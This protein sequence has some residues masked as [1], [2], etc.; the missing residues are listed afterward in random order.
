MWSHDPRAVRVTLRVAVIVATAAMVAGCFQPMYGDAKLTTAPSVAANMAAVDVNQI[1][2]PNGTPLSRI[3]VSVRDK[4]LFGL[5]GG[6]AAAP[7]VYRLNVQIN[8]SSESLIVDI[9]SG[10]PD[11]QDYA[12]NANYMLIEV[13]TGRPVLRSQ[14]YARV[15]YDIPGQAQRFARDRGLR[16]AED[17]AAQQ[18]A[19]NIK[20]RLAS[21]FVAGT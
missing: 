7:P 11:T 6:G 12:L 15:S 20:A 2:A 21:F 3:A 5:T 9:N 10:R 13:K 16:D 1:A 4:L 19:D 14:T 17:R 8:G 18:I